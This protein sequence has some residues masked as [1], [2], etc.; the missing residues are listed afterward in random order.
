MTRRR[1]GLLVSALPLAI[2]IASA[3]A[4]AAEPVDPRVPWALRPEPATPRAV[5]HPETPG[6]LYLAVDGVELRPFCGAAQNANGALNCTPLV[7]EIVEFPPYGSA[8][9]RAALLQTLS[10]LYDPYDLVL[11]LDRPPDWLPY[12]MAVIGGASSLV[13]AGDGVCGLANVAC[14]GAKRNHVS[15]TFAETCPGAVAVVAAQET[16]HNWGLEHVTAPTDVMYP[17]VAIGAPTFHDACLPVSNQTGSPITTCP[18]VHRAYCPEGDGEQQNGHAELLAAFGPRA[19]DDVAPRILETTPQDGDVWTTAD[20]FPIT[21]RFEEDSGYL[22]VRWSWIEGAPAQLD[23]GDDG[24]FTSCT[25]AVCELEYAL[26]KDTRAPYDFVVFN[27]PPAGEYEMLVEAMDARGNYSARSLRFTV[28]ESDT[29]SATGT[30]GDGTGDV[31]TGPAWTAN[32][33][34]S[35]GGDGDAGTDTDGAADGDD[36]CACRGG[37]RPR[38]V[39]WL[40]L[41][42]LTVT[43]RRRGAR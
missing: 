30:P 18:Y 9:E 22:A 31:E 11:S 34:A 36:G 16:A 27:H 35:G 41:A 17:F 25:N 24:V 19:E 6:V 28:V 21:A 7:D 12:T 33:D 5:D 26:W 13:G 38:D 15:L 42:L 29:P 37:G 4:H 8:T 23:V 14:D 10:T 43:R 32:A 2:S 1:V 20:E 3:D 39:L 40:A